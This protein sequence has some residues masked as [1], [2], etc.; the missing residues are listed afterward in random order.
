MLRDLVFK[1]LD[2]FFLAEIEEG[3]FSASSQCQKQRWEMCQSCEHF[4]EVEEGCRYCGCY[5]PHKIKDPWG[6]CPLEK[7]I[8]ND[9][10]WNHTH[11]ERLKATIIQKYPDYEHIIRKYETE[12]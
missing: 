11:Y 8:S 1:F 10:E 5:L 2:E 9:E 6:D 7:W 3:S 12:G 4:D